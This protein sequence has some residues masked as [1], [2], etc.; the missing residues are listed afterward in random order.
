M[1]VNIMTVLKG[2][3]TGYPKL[4]KAYSFTF[5]AINCTDTLYFRDYSA[6]VILTI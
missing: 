5:A 3:L 6:V 4:N 2:F 1:N